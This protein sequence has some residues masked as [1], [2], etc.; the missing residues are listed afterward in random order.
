M[1]LNTCEICGNSQDN[2]DYKIEPIQEFPG[3][4]NQAF[5]YIECSQCGCL[6]II[7]LPQDLSKYYSFNYYSLQTPN[8]KES[9]GLFMFM[10]RKRAEHHLGSKNFWGAILSKI[11][12][13]PDYFD[14]LTKVNVTFESKILDV[15]CGTGDLLLRLAQEGFVNLTGLDPLIEGDILY[16]NG[17]KIIKKEIADL[18]G[19]FD[20]IMLHH[21]F[22]HI[23]QPKEVLKNIWRLLKHDRYALI[24]IPLTSTY[25]WREYGVKWGQIEPPIHL[26]LHTPK[27]MKLLANEVGFEIKNIVFDSWELQFLCGRQ[28]SDFS[29]QELKEFK[30][31]A[32][33]LNK[34][35]DG[36]QAAFY[37][38]KP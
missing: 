11:Y 6:Q 4:N 23:P 31:K 25:A 37:L 14:W 15:G 8:V 30:V 38:Y 13:V 27:S 16:K 21:S 19:R 24:R 7:N 18:E 2:I 12:P 22:E 20:L 26:F 35:N 34:N 3:L 17:V 10:K 1:N 29:A 36:D 9:Q 28:F 32:E 33:E 5:E